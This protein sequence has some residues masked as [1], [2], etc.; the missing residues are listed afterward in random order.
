M[1]DA[2]RTGLYLDVFWELT[3]MDQS[4]G[5]DLQRF[6]HAQNESYA[7]ALEEL[8]DGQKRSHWMWYIFPQLQG[9][10]RSPT[11]I[12]FGL[13]SAAEARA[14]LGHPVLGER[15]RAVTRT[16]LAHSERSLSEIFGQPD[17][18]KFRSSMTLFAAV[19]H[20]EEGALF[21]E[22]IEAF[23]EGKPDA[24]TLELLED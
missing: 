9:L 17:D 3:M 10:G 15:L 11:A 20:A 1:S 13:K 21:R 22:A 8:Q 19:G 7:Q 24:R 2:F 4:S 5:F 23:F 12:H 18:M 6:L 14:Y 16:V